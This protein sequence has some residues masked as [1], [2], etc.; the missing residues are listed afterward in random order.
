V[1]LSAVTVQHAIAPHLD[2]LVQPVLTL[3]WSV[4]LLSEHLSALTVAAALLVVACALLS[5]LTR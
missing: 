5:R 3:L 4:W 2:T 1:S